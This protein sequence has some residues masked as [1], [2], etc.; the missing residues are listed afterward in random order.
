MRATCKL[1]ADLEMHVS[2][3]GY[4][5][6]CR[7]NAGQVNVCGL[8]KKAP[9]ENDGARNGRD[10]LY[11][12]PGSSLQERLAKA[13]LVEDSFCAVAG[14]SLSPEQAAGHAEIGIG[15]AVTMIPPVTG[16]GMS[17]A[18]ESAGHG[19][20]AFGQLEPG[21]ATWGGTAEPIARACDAGISPTA[22]LGEVV[23][24]HPADP[25]PAESGHRAGGAERLVLA[26][27]V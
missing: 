18:F 23:A 1:E 15:D 13:E 9:A 16:N 11:G 25:C 19:D 8:F 21:Q 26:E 27:G 5:G 6:L 7:I 2:S 3:R 14:L 17:M 20:R 24:T 12:P 4:V 10:L 22:G